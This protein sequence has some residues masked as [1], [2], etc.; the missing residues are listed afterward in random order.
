MHPLASEIVERWVLGIKPR[1]T[2][3]VECADDHRDRHPR[4]GGDPSKHQIVKRRLAWTGP[5]LRRDDGVERAER[6]ART[7]H[8]VSS[9]GLSRGRMHPLASQFVERWVL[10]IK[11][12]MTAVGGY[13]RRQ[14]RCRRHFLCP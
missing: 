2:A 4:A 11:P 6:A 12:R 3:E 9:S 7:S 8:S 1:M 5:G 13:C 14:Q 10:G